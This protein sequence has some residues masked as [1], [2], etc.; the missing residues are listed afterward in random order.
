MLYNIKFRQFWAFSSHNIA[1]KINQ[2]KAK[3]NYHFKNI[4]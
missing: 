4:N 3:P 1:R 2:T